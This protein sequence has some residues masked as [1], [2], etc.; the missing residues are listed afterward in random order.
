MTAT[1]TM[2][3]RT[4]E[5]AA[6]GC[7]HREAE[8]T[9]SQETKEAA[10][11][12][13]KCQ[14][15]LWV[16][17][18][19]SACGLVFGA[20]LVEHM[21]ATAMGF[22]PRL[23]E[24]YMRGVHAAVRQTPWLEA[25]VFLPLVTLVPFGLFLLAK[26]GLRYNLKKCKRGGKLRFFL[27]RISAVVI[28]AFIAFHLLTLRDWGPWSAGSET[29]KNAI[30]TAAADSTKTAIATSVRQIWDFLPSANAFSSVRCAVIVFYLLG[31][32]AAIYH[33]ANGLWTGAITWGL[34][35]SA[36]SQ[37]R[38]LWAFTAFGIMLIVLGALGW[39]AFIVAPW[40]RAI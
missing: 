30:S 23:F 2:K 18:T 17:R 15:L 36:C 16:R 28:L 25:L 26:A 11:N 7:G 21:A 31:T 29:L 19:H 32:V 40:S 14:N 37:Q 6:C 38:S 3:E 39:Y 12:P 5:T 24:H 33:F 22:R 34:S 20:F 4:P 35:Q 10:G 27:Q 8:S 1:A 13:C 9:A